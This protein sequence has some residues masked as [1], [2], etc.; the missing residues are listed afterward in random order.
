M[1]TDHASLTDNSQRLLDNI[2]IVLVNTSHP[3][4]IGGVARAMKN[5]GLTQ[6]YLVEPKDYPSPQA[7]WRAANAMDVLEG[8]KVVAT[9]DEAISDCG[10]VVGTSARERRIPWPL[11]TPRECGQRAIVEAPVHPIAIIFGREDRGL[12]NEELHKCHYHVHIPTNPNY[13]SL[14]LAAAVQVLTYELR[15]SCLEMQNSGEALHFNDWDMPPAKLDAVENYYTHLQETL[16][17]LGFIKP[18]NPRQTMTRLRRLYNR[19]RLDE[20]EVAI[21]RGMLTSIQNYMFHTDN[22][23]KRL[24]DNDADASESDKSQ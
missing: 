7:Q 16:E 14:N 15:M 21:M 2:R 18:N 20:M 6:L 10:L 13:S 1:A 24:K 23:I 11:F 19:I 9:L 12:T 5:M 8:A 17:S 3:G 22:K 4:N